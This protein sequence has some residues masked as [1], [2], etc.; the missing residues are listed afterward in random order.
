KHEIVTMDENWN[1]SYSIDIVYLE[2]QTASMSVDG[3]GQ[4]GTYNVTSFSSNYLSQ[5]NLYNDAV[6]FIDGPYGAGLVGFIQTIL[7]ESD[8]TMNDL[9]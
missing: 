8:I 7:N 5:N 6:Q 3:N 1:I 4:T 2:T 9:N